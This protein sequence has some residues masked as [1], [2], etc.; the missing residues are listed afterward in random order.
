LPL[1]GNHGFGRAVNL[2]AAEALRA[3]AEHV[4]LF[5]NDAAIPAG[6]PVIE[7]LVAEVETSP[8]IAA[9]GPIIVDDDARRAVQ[10]AGIALRP[11]FP[12]ARGVGKGLPYAVARTRTFRYDFLQGS[13]LLIRGSAF[14][15]VAGM[16]PDFFFQC[17]DADLLIRL[18]RA[19]FTSALVRDVYVTHRKSA[20]IGP[21]SDA[22]MYASVRS[23]LIFVKKHARWYELPTAVLTLLVISLGLSARSVFARRRPAVRPI[24]R[25]WRDFFAGRWGGHDGTWASG[26][27]QPK[28]PTGTTVS[29]NGRLHL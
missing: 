10:A 21:G 16:D 13:C 22:A 14:A 4:L 12:A 11:F 2:G 5:N 23:K 17:E 25:A 8:A 24:V 20:S 28:F 6:V 7:R 19:G 29:L 3:G 27:R 18:R 1:D 9:A 26:Y 15:R